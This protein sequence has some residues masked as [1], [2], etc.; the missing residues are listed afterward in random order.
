[1][2]LA[3]FARSCVAANARDTPALPGPPLTMRV[4]EQRPHPFLRLNFNWDMP[5]AGFALQRAQKFGLEDVDGASEKRRAA[6]QQRYQEETD[7][8]NRIKHA[9]AERRLEA[10]K[11][12]V[13]ILQRQTTPV[14]HSQRSI[15]RGNL[16]KAL[17]RRLDQLLHTHQQQ[18]DG[19]QLPAPAPPP[20]PISAK[21]EN[22]ATARPQE[23][24]PSSSRPAN[25]SQEGPPEHL[26]RTYQPKQLR[27][28]SARPANRSQPPAPVLPRRPS[29]A[30]ARRASLVSKITVPEMRVEEESALQP[31]DSAKLQ[32]VRPSSARPTNARPPQQTRPS[33][34]RPANRLRGG[35]GQALG[36]AETPQQFLSPTEPSQPAAPLAADLPQKAKL[37]QIAKPIIVSSAAHM[38]ADVHGREHDRPRQIAL[39]ARPPDA[40]PSVPRPIAG[41]GAWDHGATRPRVPRL[42][43]SQQVNHAVDAWAAAKRTSRQGPGITQAVIEALSARAQQPGPQNSSSL[44]MVG[45][46]MRQG[47]MASSTPRHGG[48]GHGRPATPRPRTSALALYS[49]DRTR[50]PSAPPTRET[51][52]PSMP[53]R[54]PMQVSKTT[55][56]HQT[57]SDW[58]I[59]TRN[60][61]FLSDRKK[62]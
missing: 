9:Q 48:H 2:R 45:T 39:I 49:N 14:I 41:Q 13:R 53:Q 3:T 40:R 28:V 32:Q 46:A 51:P 50:H 42:T 43:L 25:Q 19:S 58:M 10:F 16:A 37:A 59:S 34:A 1:M 23:T 55:P 60:F 22:E 47:D 20:R 7:R 17:E 44:T 18:R 5:V 24:R 21:C 6:L 15:D 29:S 12:E 30:K 56:R 57:E 33:S 36:R 27:P 26:L 52:R 54:R 4:V 35:G 11:E 8:N 31:K 38:D 61:E 62:P